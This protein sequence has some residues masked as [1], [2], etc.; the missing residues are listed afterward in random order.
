M[1]ALRSRLTALL[2]MMR[3]QF[4]IGILFP[5]TAGMLISVHQSS[6]FHLLGFLLAVG[7]GLGL[8]IATN[9]YNDIYDTRQHADA[10][11]SEARGSL[12]GGSGLLLA[13]PALMP[14]MLRLARSGVVISLVCV[15]ALLTQ[16]DARLWLGL[17]FIYAVSLFLSKYYTAAPVKLGYRGLGELFV[18]LS[19]GPLAVMLG[20]LSQN[21]DFRSWIIPFL[22]LTGLTTLTIQWFG[23]L[24]D[25]PAD[26]EAGKR[27]LAIRMGSGN[28]RFFYLALHVLIIAN[29]LAVAWLLPRTWWIL[30]A[31]AGLYLIVFPRLGITVWRHHAD[32]QDLHAVSLYNGALYFFGSM[33]YLIML[34]TALV[35]H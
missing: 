2:R 24:M 18:W 7:M 26:L 12:S 9:V 5:L 15:A 33:L 10:T 11:K 6:T 1:A 20:I 19:F 14:K 13:D 22:P 8:H 17:I 34:G 29:F 3:A 21:L 35:L 16:L 4:L 27:G 30:L 28:A 25:Y 31:V 32:P 23:Q